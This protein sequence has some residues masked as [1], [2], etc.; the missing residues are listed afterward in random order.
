MSMA[1]IK[2]P[3]SGGAGT[4]LIQ[5]ATSHTDPV[6]ASGSNLFTV[7]QFGVGEYDA[8]GGTVA[9]PL[10]SGLDSYP[11]GIAESGS[12]LFVLTNSTIG[13][14]NAFTGAAINASLVSGLSSLN[15]G[16]A[17]EGTAVPEPSTYAAILGFVSMG[18]VM[19]R[20]RFVRK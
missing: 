20:R 2:Y 3:T 12:D 6:A 8:S 10:V 11:I 17:V 4:T 5:W 9:V 1:V 7:Y 16:F 15:G 19:I 18:F 13:Q 14:Y